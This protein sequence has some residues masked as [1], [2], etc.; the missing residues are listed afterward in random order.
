MGSNPTSGK[1][2]RSREGQIAVRLHD[3]PLQYLL[4]ALREQIAHTFRER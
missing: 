2:A 1:A 4:K 3:T